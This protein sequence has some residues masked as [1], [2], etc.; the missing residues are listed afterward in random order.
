MQLPHKDCS[1]TLTNRK[2]WKLNETPTPMRDSYSPNP[3]TFLS[4]QMNVI[5]MQPPPAVSEEDAKK[6]QFRNLYKKSLN[7]TEY[8]SQGEIGFVNSNKSL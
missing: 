4:F 1:N 6:E 2:T 8:L 7:I 5:V 3:C